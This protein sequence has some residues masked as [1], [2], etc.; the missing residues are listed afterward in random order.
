MSECNFLMVVDYID[1][2]F[3]DEI[4]GNKIY[5]EVGKNTGQL[6]GI[7]IMMRNGTIRNFSFGEIDTMK[8]TIE[9]M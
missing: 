3:L 7:R 2:Q 6:F 9:R 8:K 4:D 1:E 5:A